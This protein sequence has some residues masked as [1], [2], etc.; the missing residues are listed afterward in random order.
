MSKG[1]SL[2]WISTMPHKTLLLSTISHYTFQFGFFNMFPRNIYVFHLYLGSSYLHLSM[3]QHLLPASHISCVK[4]NAKPKFP[5]WSLVQTPW[6]LTH[7]GEEFWHMPDTLSRNGDGCNNSSTIFCLYRRISAVSHCTWNSSQAC[8]LSFSN[9][10]RDWSNANC[11]A[12]RSGVAMILEIIV[13]TFII[14]LMYYKLFQGM[15]CV[16]MFLKTF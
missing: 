8:N 2:G 12:P 5:N 13:L 16:C 9:P 4:L 3:Q 10:I 6:A 7:F 14:Y 15:K 1:C 11:N